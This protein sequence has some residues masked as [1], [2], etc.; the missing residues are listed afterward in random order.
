[1]KLA[2][3]S[4]IFGSAAAFVP[5][6]QGR[7]S[8]SINSLNGWVPDES[9]FAWGLPGS[10]APVGNFDP[11]GLSTGVDL[12]TMKKWREAEAQHG[13]VAMLAA[14]GMLVTEE[15]IEYHPLFEA[16]NK[17]IGPA[18]RHLD[19][20]RAVSPFFFEILVL[21]IGGLEL[22]RALKGFVA[23]EG[24]FGF[25]ELNEDY[26][27]GD[28]GFD[29]LG[30]KPSDPEEFA[31]LATKELQNGRLAMLGAAGMI[32]QELTNGEEIFVNLGIAQDR[33]DPSTLPVQF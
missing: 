9:A 24:D 15:P 8:T 16:Y 28:V 12:G 33:F 29:P 18:I 7:A 30:L 20:V 23:P 25:Q 26:Y 13:R 19:E 14:I 31:T 6:Q 22:N 3:L 4:A 10:L 17:D 5:S 21:I 11:L 27:P 32:A 2:I 1:M